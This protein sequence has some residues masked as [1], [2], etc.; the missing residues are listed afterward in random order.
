MK[1]NKAA[2]TLIETILAVTLTTVVLTAVTGLILMTLR[3]N[4]RNIRTLQANFLAQEALE[5]VRFMRDSNWLQNYAWDRGP[6]TQDFHVD[7]TATPELTLYLVS[8]ICTGDQPCFDLS[9]IPED[10]TVTFEDGSTFERSLTFHTLSNE[11]G[12]II[13]SS[14][15][16]TATVSWQEAGLNPSVELSTTL[17]DWQ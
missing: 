7:E 9:S 8:Q 10:G 17:T 14:V 15:E 6:W 3:A 16:V 1:K 4:E 5:A 13:P 2:F 12:E 11:S